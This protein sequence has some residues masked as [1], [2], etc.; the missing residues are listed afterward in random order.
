[1]SNIAEGFSRRTAKEFIQ[2]LFVAKGSAAEI[3]SLLY[4]AVDQKYLGRTEFSE[5]YNK[6]EEV[7]KIISGFIT[8]LLRRSVRQRLNNSTTQ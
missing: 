5:L 8:S 2:Y 6:A 4:V 7:A 1:M 3:Q